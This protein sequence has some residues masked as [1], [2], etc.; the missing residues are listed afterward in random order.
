MHTQSGSRGDL[1]ALR[2]RRCRFAVV[3]HATTTDP[4]PAS[5]RTMR[6]RAR[7]PNSAGAGR[8]YLRKLRDEDPNPRLSTSNGDHA[9]GRWTFISP[10][11]SPNARNLKLPSSNRADNEVQF[12]RITDHLSKL[13]TRSLE[14]Q[15]VMAQRPSSTP[16]LPLLHD[17]ERGRER[18]RAGEPASCSSSP[19]RTHLPAL[20]WSLVQR[21]PRLPQPTLRGHARKGGHELTSLRKLLVFATVPSSRRR[22][23][24]RAV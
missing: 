4:T 11:P 13:P 6:C 7:A 1:R 22:R 5:P 14:R 21:H 9:S 15:N 24:P 16:R 10:P 23:R 17:Y 20:L 18:S 19:P 12:T 3:P 8:Y 2:L